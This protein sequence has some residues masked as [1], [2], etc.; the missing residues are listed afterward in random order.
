MAGEISTDGTEEASKEKV[1]S[2]TT[3][4]TPINTKQGQIFE[5]VNG[6]VL[7]FKREHYLL[8]VQLL[9]WLLLS[10]LVVFKG[11]CIITHFVDN[12]SD[13]KQADTFKNFQNWQIYFFIIA[14]VTLITALFSI[15][16]FLLKM[17]RSTYHIYQSNRHRL[18]IVRA[19]PS[20]MA[21]SNDTKKEEEILSIILKTVIKFN[22]TGLITKE[23]D[24]KDGISIIE[25]LIPKGH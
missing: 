23:S 15:A 3:A 11:Y 25:K 1:D 21:A 19:M 22:K 7:Q 5:A 17:F 18:N 24:V 14:R 13:P 4:G 20:F 16:S 8:L 12:V 6:A 9:I 2:E 10:L